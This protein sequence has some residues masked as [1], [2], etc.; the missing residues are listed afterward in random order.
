MEKTIRYLGILLVAQ[1]ALTVAFFSYGPD[2]AAVRP[3]TP[4]LTIDKAKVDRLVI[5]GDEGKKVVLKK[6]D[7]GWILPDHFGFP[8]NTQKTEAMLGR[9]Q[10]LK[11]G[12]PVATTSGALKR[13]KVSAE[14]FERRITFGKGKD[15]LATVFLGTSPGVRRVHART[16]Q[17]KKVFSVNFAAHEA[18]F[19]AEAWEDKE[20]LKVPEKDIEN[21]QVLNLTLVRQ[22]PAKEPTKDE[23]EPSAKDTAQTEEKTPVWQADGLK[24]GESLK[25]DDVTKLVKTLAELRIKKVL[26]IQSEDKYGL[27]TPKLKISVTQKGKGAI[28][29]QIGAYEDGS[30]FVVKVSSRPEYFEIPKYALDPLIEGATRD[31]LVMT[32]KAEQPVVTPKMET[33]AEKEEAKA[34]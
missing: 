8:A 29:Y 21:I 1:L 24:P 4:L 2:L 20:V 31:K 32:P 6:Q 27:K 15:N 18:P 16:D 19:Q 12:M 7:E 5:E 30:A 17:D 11:H 14:A 9:L 26:G 25:T 22:E 23:T 34:D 13:F 28:E 10:A 3:D 33:P